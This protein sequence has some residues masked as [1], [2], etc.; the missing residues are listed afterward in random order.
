[1]PVTIIV[2]KMT[3]SHKGSNGTSIAFPDCCKTPTPPPT[4]IPYPNIAMSSD[5][6]DK[7]SKTVKM[8]GEKV[9]LKGSKMSMSS[10]DEAG[11]AQG[12]VSNKIKG[13]MEFVN[14][15][16]DI[17]ADVKNV[18]RLGDPAKQNMGG[19]PNTVGP[20]HIQKP[21]F[22][23]GPQVE[24]CE[25][26]KAKEATEEAGPE[27]AWEKS[28]ILEDHQGPIQ[29]VV[30]AEQVIIYFRGSNP[31]CK[32]WIADGHQPK[33][34]SVLAGKTITP[35][36]PFGDEN[37]PMAHLVDIWVGENCQELMGG[38]AWVEKGLGGLSGERYPAPGRGVTLAGVVMS[39]AGS[40][41][42]QPMH[43]FGKSFDGS[44]SYK[45]KWIT[46]DYDMMDIME[47]GDKCKRPGQNGAHFARIKKALNDAMGWDGIQHG[48]QAQWV[49]KKKDPPVDVPKVMKKWLKD[50]TGKA[51]NEIVVDPTR[52]PAKAVDTDLTVVAP[53]GCVIFLENEEDV[54]KAL[55]CCGCD[56]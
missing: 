55:I 45:L 23:M 16:F 24:A 34:H 2:N 14:Y 49:D 46:G 18:A 35:G 20:F 19:S 3:A 54:K 50:T 40:S 1:M 5:L 53:A 8:D 51:K 12:V 31:A 41:L 27:T 32:K 7:A 9:C 37:L 15:S 10:G 29:D 52:G 48:P 36:K 17:K 11:V 26:T 22:A 38:A 33:P 39:T 30:D 43:G 6:S 56:K 47:V 42:G 21:D 28:G 44:R 25:E 4:P 13:K